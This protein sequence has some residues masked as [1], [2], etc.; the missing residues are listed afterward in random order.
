[1][2]SNRISLVNQITVSAGDLATINVQN[3]PGTYNPVTGQFISDPRPISQ[4]NYSFTVKD[5]WNCGTF[6]YAEQADC[7]C[8][9][10]V[11]TMAPGNL[12]LCSYDA[13]SFP[14][15]TGTVLEPNQDLLLY[16]LTV[17]TNPATWNVIA[18]SNTPSFSFDAATML[19][20]TTYQVMAVA[21]NSAAGGTINLTDPCLSVAIGP[22][23]TWRPPVTA[24]IAGGGTICAG[25]GISLPITLS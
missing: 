10:D 23:V 21:G 15:A 17:G 5:V 9:T 14:A 13:A 3:L 16:Y 2:E 18:T 24:A 4:P 1:C 19:Y 6:S 22:I 11:G 12:T 20:G 8:I 25:S 7:S